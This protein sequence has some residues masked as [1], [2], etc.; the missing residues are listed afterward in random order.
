[1]SSAQTRYA[2]IAAGPSNAAT[3]AGSPKMPDPTMLL[4]AAKASSLTPITLLSDGAMGAGARFSKR[5]RG[6]AD[7]MNQ[8]FGLQ[9]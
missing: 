1:M 7:N 2:S 5:D 8:A 6:M 3:S 4:N 9:Y